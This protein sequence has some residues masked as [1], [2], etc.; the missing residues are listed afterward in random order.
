MFFYYEKNE[1]TYASAFSCTNWYRKVVVILLY[2]RP[3]GLRITALPKTRL[4]RRLLG[5]YCLPRPPRETPQETPREPLSRVLLN[6][7]VGE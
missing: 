3:K 7:V 1:I 5:L 4:I 6:L 2:R